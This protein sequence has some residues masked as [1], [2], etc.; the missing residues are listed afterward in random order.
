MLIQLRVSAEALSQHMTEEVR[1]QQQAFSRPG[2]V[3]P[4]S[5]GYNSLY[6]KV[7]HIEN[8]TPEL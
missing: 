1:A 5:F 2:P 4:G 6:F 7:I 3:Q 8:A